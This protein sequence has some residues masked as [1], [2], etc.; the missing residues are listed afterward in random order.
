LNPQLG[1]AAA[2]GVTVTG[3]GLVDVVMAAS[4]SK[5]AMCPDYRELPADHKTA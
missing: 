2:S 1:E 3:M 5:V 4:Q